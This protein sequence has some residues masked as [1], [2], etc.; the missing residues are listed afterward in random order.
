MALLCSLFVDSAIL[1]E[2]VSD[3]R[4][5]FLCEAADAIQ[6]SLSGTENQ[7]IGVQLS[8]RLLLPY[9]LEVGERGEIIRSLI[10]EILEH[11]A[12]STERYARAIVSLVRP[13][14]EKKS[15]QLL[16]ATS[17]MLLSLYRQFM[18]TYDF[19]AAVLVLL[20]G[21]EL[22]KLVLPDRELG[23][24]HRTLS[25]LCIDTAEKILSLVFET[26]EEKVT[27]LA[28]AKVVGEA[29][30]GAFVSQVNDVPEAMLLAR[31][32]ELV[33]SLDNR[34]RDE[35]NDLILR[36]FQE[37]VDR[38]VGGT[39]LRNLHWHVLRI[40]QH[41]LDHH[42]TAT[43]DTKCI[44]I[45]MERFLQLSQYAELTKSNILDQD[46]VAS[47]ETALAN[48]LAKAFIA[49]NARKEPQVEEYRAFGQEFGINT[50]NLHNYSLDVQQRF[51]EELLDS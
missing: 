43:F 14:V 33:A 3:R 18:E 41:A 4:I 25:V 32:M 38:G 2:A 26:D 48:G 45:L 23:S 6:S 10:A 1:G 44:S 47:I 39:V 46:T 22:E 19:Q 34:E 40:A 35:T 51:V 16:D 7:D 27:Q 17:T 5:D 42:P 20:D 49:E 21:L 24:C 31:S 28:D 8:L 29:M 13:L 11:Y 30:T 50:S 12:P 15:I 37:D 9:A 36:I